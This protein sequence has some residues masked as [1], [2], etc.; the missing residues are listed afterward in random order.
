M[1]CLGHSAS[2]VRCR[3]LT[4]RTPT[5]LAPASVPALRQVYPGRLQEL[6][7]A[8]RANPARPMILPVP[9]YCRRRHLRLRR[10]PSG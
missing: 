8:H 2:L 6:R 9:P 1:S 4:R 10:N 3:F 5:M 7:R